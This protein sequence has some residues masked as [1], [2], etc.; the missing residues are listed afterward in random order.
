MLSGKQLVKRFRVLV[1]NQTPLPINELCLVLVLFYPIFPNLEI[2]RIRIGKS[3]PGGLILMPILMPLHF[4]GLT[5]N[6]NLWKLDHGS[7]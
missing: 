1:T 4:L 2:H 5:S 6:S 3:I 7:S